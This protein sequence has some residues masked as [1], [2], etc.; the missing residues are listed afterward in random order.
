MHI[1][2]IKTS[3]G[4]WVDD[5]TEVRQVAVEFF[6]SLLAPQLS[7]LDMSQASSFLDFIPSVLT[8]EDNVLL[9]QPVRLEEVKEA[10]F[11]LNAESAP[12]PDG[13]SGVFFHKCW[14]RV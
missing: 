5:S 1:G 7:P 3:A 4:L 13:F 10:V 11:L 9:M 12:G 8:S 14:D 6:E 2:K